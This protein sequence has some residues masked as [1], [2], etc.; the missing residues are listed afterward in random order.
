[1]RVLP[2]VNINLQLKPQDKWKILLLK[3]KKVPEQENKT[4]GVDILV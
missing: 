3:K 4:E 2:V 1:M